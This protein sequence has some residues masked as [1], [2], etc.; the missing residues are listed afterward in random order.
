MASFTDNIPQFNPYVQQL[1]VEAMVAV[2]MEKQRRYDEGLQKIQSNI[3][4]IAGLELA[5]PIHKQ[6]L[7][8]K[9]NELGS[10]LQTF[11]ASDFSN[12]Q[13]VNS[14]GGMIGQISKDPVILNAYKSTQ[15]IKKQQEYME[16][17]KRDGKSSPENEAWFNDELSQWYNN[18]DLN[19]SFNGEFYEYVDVDKKLRDVASK[20]K[21][22]E[23]SVDIPYQRNADG[24][25]RLDKNGNPIV[26]DA[27]LR[28]KVKGTPA[29]KILNNFYSSLNE[30]DKRQLLITGNYHYRNATAD[31]F[32]RDII[33][34]YDN[35]KKTLLDDLSKLSVELK[36][37]DKLTSAEKAEIEANIKTG[38]DRINNGYFEK[39]AA[40]EIDEIGKS[41]I[42]DFKYRLYTQKYLTGLA[43]DL[44]NE[45]YTQEIM[46][47]P[48]AQMNMEKKKLEFQV[49][50]A[51]QEHQEFL[52]SH[53]IA[54]ETL[55]LNKLKWRTEQ[56]E[57]EAERARLA[58][59]VAYG[60]LGTGVELPTLGDLTTRI[61]QTNQDILSLRSTARNELFPELKGSDGKP[62]AGEA[63]L[64]AQDKALDGLID[65]Y[66]INPTSIK[67]NDERV[68]VEQMRELQNTQVQR[69]NLFNGAVA[70]TKP[71]D[72]AL[73]ATFNRYSGS[74]LDNGMTH[75]A[76][77]LY[78]ARTALEKFI[79]VEKVGQKSDKTPSITIDKQAYINS[80]PTR[81]R[82]LGQVMSDGY[83]G[84]RLSA[85][86]AAAY[87]QANTLVKTLRTGEVANIVSQKLK[88]QSDYLA[89]NMPEVQVTYGT[90]N[91]EDKA[92]AKNV[93]YL[94]GNATR[95]FDQFGYLDQENP[96]DFSPSTISSMRSGDGSKE[97]RYVA[98]K[99]FDGS[100]KLI[101]YDK[102][103]NKQIIPL[104]QSDMATYFPDVA[105]TSF[106]TTAKFDIMSSPGRTTNVMG[107]ENPIGA[108]YSGYTIPGIAYTNYAPRVRFDVE[109]A[110]GN[111]GG[112][113]DR[114][115]VRL[116]AFDGTTWK[117]DILNQQ[118]HVSA[119]GVEEILNQ[120]GP[121]TVEE[122]L[123]KK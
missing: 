110:K 40:K 73:K 41:D 9:L 25:Y 53:S 120:I 68:F 91:M 89:S 31:T 60:G 71:Y 3:E 72:E 11:A 65:K 58:P 32:K 98:E 49:N 24:S 86:N 18:P 92:T 30:T 1:P 81:L 4:Q 117:K 7:Q 87:A 112:E 48:Y 54:K 108:K 52:M 33:S 15:H 38:V 63:L 45:S 62:L 35:K 20:I 74:K 104:N 14:V 79:K 99:N 21:E 51:K 123:R 107:R 122:V 111:N 66:I 96:G 19:T 5:K 26:D 85:N 109:G 28:I 37:N 75:T 100:G 39:E 114:F 76:Q 36:T 42:K 90:L 55:D 95:F 43:N 12:F 83:E 118:G 47:N 27:M 115:Q 119:A 94:I 13:L 59:K 23:K 8:S 105:K 78:E 93:E 113:N 97:L 34:T 17:A 64:K 61:E 16:K 121:L 69:A 50:R 106:M 29:E 101:V 57:K 44:S 82:A 102:D 2:G 10:N 88:A 116:Y 70:T 46:S 103:N 56:A 80:L 6:Y 84:K 67:D 77:D 22:I